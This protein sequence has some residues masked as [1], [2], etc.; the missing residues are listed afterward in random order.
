MAP[1]WADK[2]FFFLSLLQKAVLKKERK[3]IFF[4][5]AS[6]LSHWLEKNSLASLVVSSE[7]V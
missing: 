5:V 6:V 1:A 2:D 4:E 3:T 7:L